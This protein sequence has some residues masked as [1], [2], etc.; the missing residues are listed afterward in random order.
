[1]YEEF[2]G[3]KPVDP[4]LRVDPAALE[5]YLVPQIEGLKGPLDLT[6]FKGGQSNPT[7]CVSAADGRR[8]V[9]RRK[10][11]GP[12]L[13]SAH[14]VDRE[15]KVLRALHEAGFPVARPYLL[16]NDPSVIGTAFYVMEF[17][18]GRILWD[19]SL[20]GMTMTERFAIWDQLNS[21][22]AQLHSIDY[23]AAGLQ[24]FGKPGHYIERQIARWTKQYRDSETTKIPAMEN[25]IAW[26]PENVPPQSGASLVHGDFRL[27][28]MIFHPTEPRIL[29]VLDWELST[30]GDPLADFAYHCMS[31]HIPSGQFR[32]FA[33][34]DIASL[35]I[36]S[37]SQYMALYCARTGRETIEPEI[38][39][40]YL[41]F[42][43]FRLAA[44][45]QGIVK[46]SIEGTAASDQARDTGARAGS[47][48][49]I[50][51]TLVADKSGRLAERLS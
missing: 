12:L 46:R 15:Y 3:I 27:D 5:A 7:Y 51:W 22:I 36:P 9:M 43:L 31:W 24:D 10:P 50:G 39:R 40:F 38:W 1:M 23:R 44:I 42:N 4:R 48:A 28:N 41:A 11:P 18:E 33:E 2:L 13:P 47:M 21:V 49:E 35:G 45:L 37:E 14:A 29:A 26:L 20:P 19:Q 8:F 34:R 30:L 6:Q 25:L 17:I 32:G 16:C